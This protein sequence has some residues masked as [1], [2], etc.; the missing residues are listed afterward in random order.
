MARVSEKALRPRQY[1]FNRLSAEQMTRL[2]PGIKK[3]RDEERAAA[4]HARA[5]R[6]EREVIEAAR[7][8]NN[9]M[10]GVQQ[11]DPEHELIR[12]LEKELEELK[13]RRRALFAELKKTLDS[14][15]AMK[16][17]K[18]G[19]GKVKEAVVGKESEGKGGNQ[20]G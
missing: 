12:A 5:A 6:I 10:D 19:A 16:E 18:G 14:G 1:V 13:E 17:G 9:I 4:A 7:H 8:A 20:R 3:L 2:I 15:D 11:A